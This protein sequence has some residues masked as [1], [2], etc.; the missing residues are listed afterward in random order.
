MKVII[1]P[2]VHDLELSDR[3]LAS[4]FYTTKSSAT[5]GQNSQHLQQP[6]KFL[7]FPTEKYPAYSPYHLYRWLKLQNPSQEEL[8]FIAFSAGVVAAIGAILA[9]QNQRVKIS[10]LVA[11]DGWGVPLWGKFPIY[12]FS[13]DHFTHWSSAI[14]G[15]GKASFYSD[16]TVEHLTM[17]HSPENCT[18]WITQQH[19]P[20]RKSTAKDYLQ[21]ILSIA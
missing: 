8:F 2:G 21:E 11:I 12:R 9:L 17:W 3:F 15:T 19:L 20:P 4:V 1:C 6:Q 16:P 18:G 7:L 5:P 14:L 10:G 13:H